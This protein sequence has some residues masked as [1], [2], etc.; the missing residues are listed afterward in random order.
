[1]K[2]KTIIFLLAL[3]LVIGGLIGGTVAFLLDQTET[4]VNTFTTSNIGITLTETNDRNLK[5]V[6]G[7]T[8]NKDPKITVDAD[9]EPCYLFVKLE[10]SANFN[11]FLT[12]D[13]AT[14]WTVLP[15]VD[16]VWY[17]KVTA[18]N[19][20]PIS[21]LLGDE[22][23][24]NS[25]VTKEMMDSLTTDNFPNLKVTAYA[26]QLYMSNDVEFTVQQAWANFTTSP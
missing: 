11:A 15:D 2:K 1:M 24:V 9:S 20:V 12:S 25:N 18:P 26:S 3:V 6:P 23:S 7:H 17:R 19:A 5:M 22:V 16:G 8:I 21:I 14:G 13:I 4:V 10:K